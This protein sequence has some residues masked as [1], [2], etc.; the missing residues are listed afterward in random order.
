MPLFKQKNIKVG[1]ALGSGVARGL[2]HIGVLKVLEEAQVPID[3]IAGTSIGALVGACYARD[4]KISRA[5]EAAL[6][7]GWREFARLLYPNLASMRKGLIHSKRVEEMLRYLIG[8]AQF[9]DLLLP[10]AA[11]ATDIH[12]GEEVVIKTGLVIDAVRASISIPAVFVPVKLDGRCLVDGGVTNPVP[13]DVVRAMG[14]DIVIAV[15]VLT[16]PSRQTANPMPKRGS[17]E[18]PNLLNTLIQS[19]YIMEHEITKLKIPI[20]DVTIVPSVGH[21]EAHEFFRAK[22]AIEAGIKAATDKLPQ[23]QKLLGKH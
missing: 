13:A 7:V 9:K 15:N 2:A 20:A 10:L 12:T 8:D 5:E 11:V 19:M 22:E 6:K 1:L 4:G 17:L 14:A 18:P 23:I 16:D 21:L 3:M